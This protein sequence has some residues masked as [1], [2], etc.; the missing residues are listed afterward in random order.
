MQH[1]IFQTLFGVNLSSLL[2]HI[3]MKKPRSKSKISQWFGGQNGLDLE[4]IPMEEGSGVLT[5]MQRARTA[6]RE[7]KPAA[8]SCASS[9]AAESSHLWWG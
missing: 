3:D 7:V 4:R 1:A 2:V 8:R 5:L 9:F 6:A